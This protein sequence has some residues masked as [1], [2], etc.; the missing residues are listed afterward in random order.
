MN[1]RWIPDWLTGLFEPQPQIELAPEAPIK[2]VIFHLD[3]M[4]FPSPS[5]SLCYGVYE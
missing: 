1:Y 3:G 5:V 4:S 2:M